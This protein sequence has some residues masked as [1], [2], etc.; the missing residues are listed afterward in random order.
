MDRKLERND[1]RKQT[2]ESLPKISNI[3][4]RGLEKS[5]T[6]KF[7]VKTDE[8]KHKRAELS[9]ESEWQDVSLE[10]QKYKYKIITEYDENNQIYILWNLSQKITLK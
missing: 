8:K 4:A 2:K 9:E 1:I 10:N 7:N 3:I 5:K 6:T